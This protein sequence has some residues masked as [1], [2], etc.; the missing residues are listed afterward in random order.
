MQKDDIKYLADLARIELSEEEIEKYADD[1]TGIL[2]FI[3][4][5][6]EA[7]SRNLTDNVESAQVRN[8]FRTDDE[9]NVTGQFTQSLLKE[10]PE[11]KDDFV[12]VKPI[13]NNND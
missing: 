11:T 2:N 1:V 8:V 12:R 10:S 3:N 7:D 4:Q 6:Q 13:L 9:T 5:I